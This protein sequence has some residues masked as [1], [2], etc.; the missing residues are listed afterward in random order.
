MRGDP[1]HPPVGVAH[2][3]VATAIMFEVAV[4]ARSEVIGRLPP[5]AG[6]EAV[7]MPAGRR[8]QSWSQ[9]HRR[10]PRCASYWTV[11]ATVIRLP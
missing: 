7:A 8:G 10:I 4:T 5:V 6:F 2:I 1:V 3:V 9:M 11:S